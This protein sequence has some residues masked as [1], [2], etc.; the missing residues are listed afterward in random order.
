MTDCLS[1]LVP[2]MFCLGILA[3][4]RRGLSFPL[5]WSQSVPP[6]SCAPK[7]WRGAMWRTG[8]H[9][10]HPF[11]WP[12]ITQV[13]RKERRQKSEVFFK[14]NSQWSISTSMSVCSQDEIYHCSVNEYGLETRVALPGEDQESYWHGEKPSCTMG[15]GPCQL[16][17]WGRYPCGPSPG[18][19]D[20][21]SVGLEW[22][23][24]PSL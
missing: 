4:Y 7:Q 1:L 17:P 6:Q 2:V 3:P 12:P 5:P 9:A 18:D 14:V 23:L 11:S 8:I 15:L 24:D 19:S 10:L 22:W 20:S 16:M 21:E 13:L